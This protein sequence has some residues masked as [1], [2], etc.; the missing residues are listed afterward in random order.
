MLSASASLAGQA[1]AKPARKRW[2]P[3]N[4]APSHTTG[5]ESCGLVQVLLHAG[6]YGGAPAA[7][8]AFRV[9]REL[10][11]ELGLEFEG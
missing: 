3:L 9:A 5:I 11:A 1:S 6:V 4:L 10:M 7:V 8:E 2:C